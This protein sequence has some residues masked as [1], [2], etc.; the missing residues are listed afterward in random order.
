MKTP[1]TVTFVTDYAVVTTVVEHDLKHAYDEPDH[2]CLMKCEC[3]LASCDCG[4]E[5]IEA[6]ALEQ[7][8]WSSLHSPMLRLDSIEA[9]L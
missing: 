6:K 4:E 2:E 5:E 7:L 9:S 3:C 8:R 1:F